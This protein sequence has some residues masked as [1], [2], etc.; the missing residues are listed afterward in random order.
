VVSCGPA[1]QTATT[2]RISA[3]LP[4]ETPLVGMYSDNFRFCQADEV[5]D[6]GGHEEKTEASRAA[7]QVAAETK[8]PVEREANARGWPSP[9]VD[10][11]A[12]W[13]G[14]FNR[15]EANA[16]CFEPARLSARR[17]VLDIAGARRIADAGAGQDRIR[18]GV[19]V[20]RVDREVRNILKYLVYT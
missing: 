9:T 2:S 10:G 16:I 18:A 3:R 6:G 14:P 13:S 5:Q 8:R 11:G 7:R 1:L 4:E 19:R 17:R 15:V 20:A 12:V